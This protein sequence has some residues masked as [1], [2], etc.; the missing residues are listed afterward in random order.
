M[1]YDANGVRVDADSTPTVTVRKN[2]VSV[3]DIVTITKRAV[4]TGIYDCSYNP[5]LE[6]EG[7][8]FEI[9]ETA[10]ISAVTY[11][12][13]WSIEC[14]AIAFDN[15][16]DPVD[17]GQI[18]GDGISSD[19]LRDMFNGVGYIDPNGPSYQSQ[20]SNIA[21]TG[22]AINTTYTSQ[23]IVSGGVVSGNADNTIAR[24]GVYYQLNDT[25]GLL[26]V[27][28]DFEIGSDGVPT[29][30]TLYGY[31]NGGNDSVQIQA[32][33]WVTSQYR[34]L[35]TIQGSNG[36]SPQEYNFALFTSM[37]GSGVDDGTVRIRLYDATLTNSDLFIDQL[38]TSYSVVNRSIGYSN[39]SIWVNGLTGTS[40]TV[41]FIDGT[42]DNPVD[43]YANAISLNSSLN[44]RRFTFSPGDVATLTQNM[45]AIEFLGTNY[46]VNLNSQVPPTVITGAEVTGASTSTVTHYMRECRVGTISTPVTLNSGAVFDLCGLV[47]IAL[48]DQ[49]GA[50]L[51]VEF[52]DCHGNTQESMFPGGT[53]DFGVSAGT[54]HE[55]SFQRW[56]GPVTLKNLKDGD[57]VYFHGNGTA[58]FDPSCTGGSFR[59][60]GMINIVDNAGGAV[61]VLEDGRITISRIA[62][63]VWDEPA[64][65]HVSALSTGLALFDTVNNSENLATT[66]EIDGSGGYQFTTLALENAPSGGGG[67]TVQQIVDGVWDEPVANH[68]I[69]GS[70][71]NMLNAINTLT[72]SIYGTTVTLDGMI[73]DA[74]LGNDRFTA[75]ALENAPS[76]GGGLTV[77]QIV[78]GVWDE[79][80][81]AHLNAGSFGVYL[82]SDISAIRTVVDDTA[83]DIIDIQSTLSSTGVVL[84]PAQKSEL[85][86]LVWDESLSSHV[87]AG[88][89][90]TAQEIVDTWGN[91]PQGSYTTSGTLGFYLDAQV[92][93]AGGGGNGLYQATIRVQDNAT[94]ALQGARVNVDGTT[95]TAT[96]STSGEVTFNLDSGVY[97]IEVSPP[98]GYDTPTGQV[99]TVSTSDPSDTIFTLTQTSP[100]TGCD[101]AWL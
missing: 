64:A 8:L 15:T 94:N 20:L 54:N 27:Q 95:L 85:V 10:V 28:F 83:N 99:L 67:L 50:A 35:G 84:T 57:T 24:D 62:D 69:S 59:V 22:A 89:C 42:A 60:A 14:Q 16:S 52:L 96:T 73:E 76:G 66:L 65:D 37:V 3:G 38:Y 100:P 31:L 45:S 86:D 6:Q 58:I 75:I 72:V 101:I 23:N 79:P 70:T 41:P 1:T 68:L 90:P 30:I 11:D 82:N 92:S 12:Q 71:S 63:A 51:D 61:S 9:E 78:D 4:T 48:K 81:S 49:A 5:A 97:L 36:T 13:T 87:G 25:A 55:V 39:G 33:D 19:N 18:S 93:T 98:A 47:N 46:I 44:L 40:G 56:G 80:Q 91:Q 53:V 2:G 17:V 43:S 7:D 74:G 21:V 34:T 29:G 77:Q 32:Y 26:D 88:S